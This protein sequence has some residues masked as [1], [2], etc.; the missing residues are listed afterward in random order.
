MQFYIELSSWMVALNKVVI[1][2]WIDKYIKTN[3][4]I[5]QSIKIQFLQFYIEL[6]S[7]VEKRLKSYSLNISKAFKVINAY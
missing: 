5:T 4:Y 3:N 6:S 2:A 7:Y 1:Y